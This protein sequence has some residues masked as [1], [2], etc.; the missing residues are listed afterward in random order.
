MDGRAGRRHVLLGQEL[1]YQALVRSGFF[2]KVSGMGLMMGTRL[3]GNVRGERLI[4]MMKGRK[5]HHR[6][7]NR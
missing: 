2:R 5:K 1:A 6:Q 3:A 4:V 7:D